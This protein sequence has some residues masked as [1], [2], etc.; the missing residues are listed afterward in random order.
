MEGLLDDPLFENYLADAQT[1]LTVNIIDGRI[2]IGSAERIIELLNQNI[3]AYWSGFPHL[4]NR[5]SI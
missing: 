4:F 5:R 2:L 1:F 3:E